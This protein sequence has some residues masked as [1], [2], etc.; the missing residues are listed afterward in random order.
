[1][2]Q[3]VTVDGNEIEVFTEAEVKAREEA[4]TNAKAADAA[5]L[6]DEKAAL[7]RQIEDLKASGTLDKDEQVKRLRSK[8]EEKEKS[9]NDLS[10]KVDSFVKASE[11][12]K[13]KSFENSKKAALDSMAG[14]DADLRKRI[15]F[16]FENYR[17]H[18]TT[19]EGIKERLEKAYVLAGGQGR[20]TPG[21]L[22]T[23][24]SFSARGIPATSNP[25]DG[26]T[27]NAKKLAGALG[28]T[29]DGIKKVEEF[30]KARAAGKI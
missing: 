24:F 12:E 22:D 15:E 19:P 26:W 28:V 6:A 4:A 30:K 14:G 9:I 13:K 29:E 16:E 20:A 18:D 2:P 7:E 3:K 25:N 1:M 27:E 5:R 21:A 11:E 10:A 8:I 17:A 23:G